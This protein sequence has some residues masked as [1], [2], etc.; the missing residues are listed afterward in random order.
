MVAIGAEYYVYLDILENWLLFASGLLSLVLGL[1]GRTLVT[2]DKVALD[3]PFYHQAGILIGCSA[4]TVSLITVLSRRALVLVKLEVPVASVALGIVSF[5]VG[6][7]IDEIVVWSEMPSVQRHSKLPTQDNTEEAYVLA[8]S[9]FTQLHYSRCLSCFV[10]AT[11]CLCFLYFRLVILG[12]IIY[13]KLGS[14]ENEFIEPESDQPDEQLIANMDDGMFGTKPEETEIK[15]E[16]KEMNPPPDE[17]KSA[18]SKL[19]SCFA[20]KGAE[21]KEDEGADK[22]NEEGEQVPGETERVSGATPAQARTSAPAEPG[23]NPEDQKAESAISKLFSC[24]ARKGAEGKEDEGADKA[25]EEAEQVPG[26][27]ERVSGATPAQ[28]RTSAPA[29]PGENPEDQKAE[30]AISKLFSCF[31]RKGAEGKE[32]EGAD[33]ANEEAEQV[34]VE[35]ERVS[36]AT[37]AQVR[38]SA[39]AEPVENPEENPEEKPEEKPEDRKAGKKKGDKKKNKKKKGGASETPNEQA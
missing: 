23:E 24:F 26:E 35:T 14:T 10:M 16:G 12:L 17:K 2:P 37:P 8:F 30:S 39:P 18:I 31:A 1:G 33:K 5:S 27:T 7:L 4:I 38:T 25:N 9:N 3:Y 19:F 29:E 36:G 28:A 20:R 34:P 13:D 32:D 11:V 6:F 21:G 22:A 15:E